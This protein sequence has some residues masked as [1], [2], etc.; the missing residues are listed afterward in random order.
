M[1]HNRRV[2]NRKQ[3]EAGQ[4]KP[5]GS[6]SQ[7]RGKAQAEDGDVVDSSGDDINQGSDAGE[8]MATF[9]GLAEGDQ[10]NHIRHNLM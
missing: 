9:E 1:L 5:K 4:Q 6:R 3:L 7:T 8:D 10:A 2:F